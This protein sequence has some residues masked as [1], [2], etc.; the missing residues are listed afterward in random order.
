MLHGQ[1][2]EALMTLIASGPAHSRTVAFDTLV[3]RHLQ[4]AHATAYRVSSGIDHEDIVQEAFTKVWQTAA[5]YQANKAKFTTWFY[6]ILVNTAIDR[7]R[8]R[9]KLTTAASEN[10]EW[11]A[12]PD[13]APDAEAVLSE[14]QH[15]GQLHAAVRD[16]PE[17]QRAAIT[18]CYEQGMSNQQ[19][20]EIMGLH[21]KALEGLLV[22]AR[23]NLKDR[24]QNWFRPDGSD[25]MINVEGASHERQASTK[26]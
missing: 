14:K 1:S 17:R 16:L 10:F 3:R 8:A 22:R 11:D 2:D 24:L 20:A 13:E 9:K 12:L 19:A 25:K 23:K 18:L 26:R 4:L 15:L 5:S 21:V 7:V 6:R